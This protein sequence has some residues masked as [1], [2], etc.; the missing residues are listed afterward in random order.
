[1]NPLR[2]ARIPA[3]RRLAPCC[4]ALILALAAAAATAADNE[5]TYRQY[6]DL[7]RLADGFEH[8]AMFEPL[9]GEAGMFVAVAERFGNVMVFKA[10]GKGVR[11][12]WKSDQ[13]AGIPEEVVVADL[14]GDGLDDALLCRTAAARVYV[15]KLED[16][17]ELWESL[18][19]EYS[20]I[21]CFTVANVD[22]DPAAEIV[23][24]ADNHLVYVDTATFSKQFTSITEYTAT[25]VRCGDVD[26]DG[27]AEI[28]LNTGKVVDA[29]SGEVEWEDETFFGRI[30]LVDLDGNGTVDVLT[31]APAGGP[32]KVFDVGGRREV[33]FQ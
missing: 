31:E 13:L 2:P 6:R 12:V 10:D 26:A 22:E 16:F 1:M 17:S 5:L 33:R 20:S 28:V 11:T 15:W 23:M 7:A 30:E 9:Q 32:L 8:V 3:L 19:G 29:R 4:L 24:V 14:T 21:T 25:M 27:T 18:S